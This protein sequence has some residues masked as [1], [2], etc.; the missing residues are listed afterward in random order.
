[1][2]ITIFVSVGDFVGVICSSAVFLS[3]YEPIYTFHTHTH[4]GD[5]R[6]ESSQWE[7]VLLCNNVSDWPSA[8]LESA[9]HVISGFTRGSQVSRARAQ[10]KFSQWCSNTDSIADCRVQFRFYQSVLAGSIGVW[11]RIKLSGEWVSETPRFESWA[12]FQYP[13]RRLIVRSREVSKP[14]DW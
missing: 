4:R 14:R 12:P 3:T 6:F 2:F 10:T 13:R 1:M 5:S 8:N 9:L 11:A 7:T